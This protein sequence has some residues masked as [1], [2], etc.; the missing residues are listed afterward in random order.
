[1]RIATGADIP[2][3][4]DM[5]ALLT[6]AVQGPVPVDR[7]WT[8][9]CLAGFIAGR[10]SCVWVTRQGFLAASVVPS[11]INPAPMAIEHGWYAADGQGVALLRAYEA[12]AKGRGALIVQ[13]SRAYGTGGLE[14]LGY[15]A[16]ECAWIKAI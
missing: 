5:V 11:V 4:T 13:L 10:D 14:R 12:W 9:R 1:M 16:A 2:R 8:G 6:A 15:R 3:I 7:A